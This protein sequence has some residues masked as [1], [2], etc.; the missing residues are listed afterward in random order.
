MDSPPV[1]CPKS[2]IPSVD[3]TFRQRRRNQRHS[4]LQQCIAW[5]KIANAAPALGTMMVTPPWTLQSATVVKMTLVALT[6]I[7][8]VLYLLLHFITSLQLQIL[9]YWRMLRLL[10]RQEGR[11]RSLL[12]EANSQPSKRESRMVFIVAG[13]YMACWLPFYT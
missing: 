13:C 8:N 9:L 1:C 10:K 3:V 4:V 12:S 7:K 6:Q 5:Q 11:C 2:P